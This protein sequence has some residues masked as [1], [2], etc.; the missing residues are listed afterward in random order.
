M[1]KL[2]SL[3]AGIDVGGTT[4]KIALIDQEGTIHQKWE[5]PTNQQAQGAYI[6]EETAASIKAK[7]KQ[8]NL[9]IVAAGVGAPGFIDVEH[10]IIT[11]AV[12]VGWKDYALKQ[13]LEALLHV[14]VVVDN[15]ANL[16]AGGEKWKG[17]GA[18]A[19][20]LLAVTLGTGVGGGIIAGGEII[21]GEFGMAGEIGHIQ[22]VRENG[23]RCNCGKNG[24]LETVSSA[25]GIARLGLEKVQTE[26]RGYLQ[27][28]LAEQGT[29]S[30][31]DVLDGA[32]AGDPDAES[33]FEEAA[34]HLG[35]ALAN[36]CNSLNPE[37]I[38]VGGGVSKGGT[39]LTDAISRHFKR[40]AIPVIGEKTKIHLAV[41]G[42]DAGVIGAAWLASKTFLKGA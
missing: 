23:A 12:N 31:K 35:F 3:V 5:I 13:E 42:N 32:R 38:V 15:D 10:G 27:E 25:T 1:G 41:L 17:S 28:R 18:G 14:P 36:L 4:V 9:S 24:C 19:S 22:S 29:I 26:R 20:N 30:A 6:M 16:A 7:L 37:V 34:E 39:F 8:D 33:V 2:E 40:F 21:H 11:E